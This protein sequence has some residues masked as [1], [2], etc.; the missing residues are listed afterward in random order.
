MTETT[1]D[2]EGA[3]AA[4]TTPDV[5]IPSR[6]DVRRAFDIYVFGRS[7]T[8]GPAEKDTVFEGTPARPVS[9]PAAGG[10]PSDLPTGA[11]AVPM[12]S[13]LRFDRGA[14]TW[15]QRRGLSKEEAPSA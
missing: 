1:A 10:S 7:R 14:G 8:L 15:R 3:R 13:E 9:L 12:R 6:L 5:G 11:T 2:E 4:A